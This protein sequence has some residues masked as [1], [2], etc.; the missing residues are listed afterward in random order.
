MRGLG[1]DFKN[2]TSCTFD[3][4]YAGEGGIVLFQVRG[5]IGDQSGYKLKN[6]IDTPVYVLYDV[7]IKVGVIFP[8][9]LSSSLLGRKRAVSAGFSELDE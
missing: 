6:Y 4:V 7:N 8:V 1:K 3:I 5:K 9:A 2:N